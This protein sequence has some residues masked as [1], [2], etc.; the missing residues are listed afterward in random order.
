MTRRT[1]SNLVEASGAD[2][3]PATLNHFGLTVVCSLHVAGGVRALC[4]LCVLCVC[5]VFLLCVDSLLR[6]SPILSA[7]Q[8]EGHQ[9]NKSTHNS[10]ED[11]E[12]L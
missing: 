8:V 1:N 7:T 10:L 5:G 9:K 11:R 6:Y 2:G 3:G 4:V 12:M